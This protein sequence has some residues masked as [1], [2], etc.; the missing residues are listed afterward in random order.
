MST[1]EELLLSVTTKDLSETQT[2]NFLYRGGIVQDSSNCIISKPAEFSREKVGYKSR[3]K[4]NIETGDK[5]EEK[6]I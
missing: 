1:K 4:L 2:V 5:C 3:E 6:S